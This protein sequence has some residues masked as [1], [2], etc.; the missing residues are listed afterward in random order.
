MVVDYS[1]TEEELEE[2]FGKE[3]WKQLPDEVY[4]RY[5]FTPAKVEVEKH[6]VKVYAG[7]KTDEI[8]RSPHPG[9]L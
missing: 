1:M 7:K 5:G 8:V 3:G 6:R 2:L 9:S 4:R